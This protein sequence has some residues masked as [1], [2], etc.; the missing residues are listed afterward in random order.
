MT[1]TP[2][3]RGRG[4]R[5][6]LLP[7]VFLVVV[8]AA[9]WAVLLLP[10]SSAEAAFP[11]KNGRI[12]FAL[13]PEVG[14]AEI[15][16]MRPDGSGPR[17]VTDNSAH[18]V[19]PAWSPD[20]TKL[21]FT[22]HEK[23]FVKDMGSGRV[24]RLTD[25]VGMSSFNSA[26]S[27]S[28]ARIAFDSSRDGDQEIYAMD[29]SD[30]SG[31]K[32]LTENGNHDV[33][34]TWSP[35]GTRIAFER[36]YDIWVMNADGTGQKNLTDTTDSA[37]EYEPDWSPDG[38]KIAFTRDGDIWVM[39]P[40]GTGQKNLTNT[41]ALGEEYPAWSPNGRKVAFTEHDDIWVMDADGTNPTN[42]TNTPKVTEYV[43]DWQPVPT[44]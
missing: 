12:A 40:D 38:A 31:V 17:P 2:A 9:C 10:A 19:R 7:A 27:P 21:S 1:L 41:P 33:N 15:H 22:R 37:S 30:G 35:D 20:G 32:K 8:T 5:A 16:T 4:G 24:V 25:N 18:D 23:I 26:W 36:D 39:D 43:G 3:A 29:S 44:P 28:G 6:V 11:G 14:D 42:R 34:P 13:F